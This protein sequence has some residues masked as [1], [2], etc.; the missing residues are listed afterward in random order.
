MPTIAT[1]KRTLTN[2]REATAAPS[3]PKPKLTVVISVTPPG[4]AANMSVTTSK[5]V[6]GATTS[7]ETI[8]VGTRMAMIRREGTRAFAPELSA[9]LD[10]LK[11]TS[12]PSRTCN[13]FVV[14]VGTGSCGRP[15]SMLRPLPT[16]APAMDPKRTAAGSSCP[17]KRLQQQRPK[18]S[19]RP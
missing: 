7:A 11:P 10:I 1:A 2:C 12:M 3:A 17:E 19:P 16:A 13:I 9:S 18:R 6:K 14:T 4:A 15:T 8:A 5:D